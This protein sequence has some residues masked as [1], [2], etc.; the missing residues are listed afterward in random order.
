MAPKKMKS[1]PSAHPS[2]SKALSPAASGASKDAEASKDVNAAGGV[3]GAGGAITT[4][5]A[6]NT[7]AG[8][9]GAEEHQ[10]RLGGHTL[11]GVGEGVAPSAPSPPTDEHNRSNGAQFRVSHRP[12]A[13][14]TAGAT[15]AHV[16]P[17]GQVDQTVVLGG[18]TNSRAPST[19]YPAAQTVTPQLRGRG[20]TVVAAAGTIRSKATMRPMSSTST[21]STASEA[22]ARAQLLLRF[23][24]MAEQMDECH[25][26]IQSLLGFAEAEGSR[27][28]GPP[29]SPQ[30]MATAG[31]A[32]RTEGAVPMVQSPS[33]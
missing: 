17:P 7:G 31:T 13:A 33:W 27:Q 26:T 32:G 5:H 29:R 6:A 4:P 2:T 18:A 24:P 15:V 8:D 21:P 14:P 28:A 11:E 23:P 1:G 19:H 22:M 16:S 25:A 9:V 20:T 12:P 10:Q 30:A 3:V